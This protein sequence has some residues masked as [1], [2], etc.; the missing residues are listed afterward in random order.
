MVLASAKERVPSVMRPKNRVEN[1][2]G[3]NDRIIP[4][5]KK[6]GLSATALAVAT[7]SALGLT[8]CDDKVEAR[9]NESIP[10]SSAPV[11]PGA[12][13]STA[14]APTKTPS[15]S[16]TIEPTAP[17][18]T[19][20][21]TPDTSTAEVP[22]FR[23]WDIAPD[24]VERL[25]SAETDLEKWS[26][27]KEVI[28]NNNEPGSYEGD[29]SLATR[30]IDSLF[31]RT[32]VEMATMSDIG[33]D[34]NAEGGDIISQEWADLAIIDE[35]TRAK[36][37]DITSNMRNVLSTSDQETVDVMIKL[38]NED[39][40]YHLQPEILHASSDINHFHDS[41]TGRDYNGITATGIY[42]TPGNYPGYVTTITIVF[43]ADNFATQ[44]LREYPESTPGG[45]EIS[46]D[47]NAAPIKV[48]EIP[49][50]KEKTGS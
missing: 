15:V 25:Q 41:A 20:V 47:P 6:I 37:L 48:S 12:S 49:A 2:S 8:G 7:G 10:A 39:P 23:E 29:T 22:A 28:I 3:S 21:E 13:E 11:T 42:E 26:V 40:K 5:Y 35:D 19:E 30:R 9:P 17:A 4:L 24:T 44:I 45:W 27:L 33:Q 46:F 50:V 34:P 32:M 36:F 16:E 1:P 14:P 31:N 43:D 38:H 18:T